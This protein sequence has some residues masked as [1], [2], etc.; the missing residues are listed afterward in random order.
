[1]SRVIIPES[2][3]MFNV[4]AD[5][6]ATVA[7]ANATDLG[8]TTGQ[9]TTMTALATLFNT[10]FLANEVAKLAAKSA[11]GAKDSTR[12]STEG[13]MRN[14]AKVIN[15]D[16]NIPNALK[17]SLGISITPSSPGTV[18]VPMSLEVLSTVEGVNQLNW[19]A[20]GNKQTTTYILE[21]RLPGES[22]WVYLTSLTAKKFD[23]TGQIVGQ[24]VSYRVSAKRGSIQSVPSMAVTAYVDSV[25]ELTIFSE[26][27]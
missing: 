20:N 15:A 18:N 14:I 9:T 10:D 13:Y 5:N 4:W 2:D 11:V 16:S 22:A 25:P 21:Y 6:F 24:Q 27:A 7:A 23:H 3:S 8:L 17:A 1:M 26:A 12:F 19:K